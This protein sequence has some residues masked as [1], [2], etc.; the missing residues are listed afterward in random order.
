MGA[1]GQSIHLPQTIGVDECLKV[2]RRRRVIVGINDRD[3][4]T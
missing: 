2:A 3:G 4:L 1:A